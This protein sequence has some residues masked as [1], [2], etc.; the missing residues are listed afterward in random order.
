MVTKLNLDPS[1]I[2]RLQNTLCEEF[3][4]KKPTRSKEKIKI[5]DIDD[6]I[7]LRT[8]PCK[9]AKSFNKNHEEIFCSINF[10][11]KGETCY[12]NIPLSTYHRILG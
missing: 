2:V 3:I 4:Y 6:V 10:I 11:L 5:S 7:N 9:I 12:L 8:Y 1:S